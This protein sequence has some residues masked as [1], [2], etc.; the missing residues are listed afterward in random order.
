MPF[1]FFIA[2]MM[3]WWCV[4]RRDSSGIRGNQRADDTL[5]RLNTKLSANPG[6]HIASVDAIA[7]IT[8]LTHELNE[9]FRHLGD[10]PARIEHRCGETKPRQGRNDHM[11]GLRCRVPGR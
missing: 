11:E 4:L 6:S 7:I 1:L 3:G 5:P 2:Q 9:R 8:K 10:L